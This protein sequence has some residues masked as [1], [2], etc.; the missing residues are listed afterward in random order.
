M[1]NDLYFFYKKTE[2]K[3]VTIISN[4]CI[5]NLGDKNDNKRKVNNIIR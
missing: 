1:L 5:I 3:F 4:R 2:Q